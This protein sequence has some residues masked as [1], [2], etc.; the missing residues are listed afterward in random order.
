MVTM[1]ATKEPLLAC[2]AWVILKDAGSHSALVNGYSRLATMV[3][4]NPRPSG[5]ECSDSSPLTRF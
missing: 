5:S 2:D 3:L 4:S 1:N